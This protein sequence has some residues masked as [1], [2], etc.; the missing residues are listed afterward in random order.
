MGQCNLIWLY[1]LTFLS[2]FFSS[3]FLPPLHG[4]DALE[5][6]LTLYQSGVKENNPK[7]IND[8]LFLLHSLE[9]SFNPEFGSGKLYYDMANSLFQLHDW[10]FALL[11]YL[12]AEK[13]LPKDA[14]QDNLSKTYQAVE[15]E[16]PKAKGR[17]S[18]F[19][20]LFSLPLP[21][22]LQGIGI[23]AFLSFL[24]LL[25]FIFWPR[26]KLLIF[27]LLPLLFALP[28]LVSAFY[29]K[30]I[31][32]LQA[33]LVQG[34]FLYTHAK[35]GAPQVSDHFLPLGSRVQVLTVKGEGRFLQVFTEN[36]EV[37]FIPAQAARIY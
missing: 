36:K 3:H 20:H 21:R 31:S 35:T 30:Y 7:K 4:S 5:N 1:F 26:K 6:A 23:A 17:L 24:A 14:V 28:L 29:I 27:S 33:I 25:L 19:L 18:R 12:K 10:P 13:L 22:I 34:S 11:Y 16:Q 32:P 9:A 2:L 37:G 15:L 8:S